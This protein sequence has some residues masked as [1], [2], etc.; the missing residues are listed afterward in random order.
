MNQMTVALDALV[1]ASTRQSEDAGRGPT[2]GLDLADL[3]GL[4]EAIECARYENMA[5]VR[6]RDLRDGERQTRS[7]LMRRTLDTAG[8]SDVL[9]DVQ[10]RADRSDELGRLAAHRDRE[11]TD[12]R[13]DHAAEIAT[14]TARLTA[15]DAA[16]AEAIDERRAA[17]VRAD[18][19]DA[20][21]AA[22]A[23]ALDRVK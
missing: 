20:T 17:Q 13:A 9:R 4:A 5:K 12:Q 11:L 3:D 18:D 2:S 19:A 23:R 1:P 22:V 16:L 10:A 6:W 8:I 15:L 7:A 14:L 21:I